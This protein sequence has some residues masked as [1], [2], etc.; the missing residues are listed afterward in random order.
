MY[1][2]IDQAQYK[3]YVHAEEQILEGKPGNRKIVVNH[4]ECH[5]ELT[6]KTGLIRSLKYY[7]KD[8]VQFIE[9]GYQ[10]FDTTPTSFVVNSN[11][12]TYEYNQF[13]ERYQDLANGDGDTIKEKLPTKHCKKNI[14]LVKPANQ[15]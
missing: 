11:L 6:T 7:Y 1:S 3:G 15:N 13:I 8:T 4:L 12:E 9:V 2:Q 10:V 14:W 5:R